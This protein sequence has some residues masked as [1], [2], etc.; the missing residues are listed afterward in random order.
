M[1]LR[2]DEFERQRKEEEREREKKKNEIKCT[3]KE[4]DTHLILGKLK[5]ANT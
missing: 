1:E 5:G 4:K 2:R 3:D